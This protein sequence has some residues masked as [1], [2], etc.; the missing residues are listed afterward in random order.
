MRENR[1]LLE[2][3][4]LVTLASRSASTFSH[5]PF[6]ENSKPD[7]QI[8][9]WLKPAAAYRD[10]IIDETS[11]GITANENGAYAIVLTGNCEVDL[12]RDQAIRYTAAVD[13]P[14]VFRLTKTMQHEDPDQ[15]VVRVL[16]S[17]K[18]RSKIA[19]KAGLRYDGLWV[20]FSPKMA[21]S[22]S[23]LIRK[24][25]S[26]RILSFSVHLSPPNT[27]HTAFTLSRVPTQ[28]SLLSAL[29]NPTSDQLDDW[30]DYQRLK[31][32]D[33]GDDF[34]MLREILASEATGDV[35]SRDDGRHGSEDSGY[36]SRKGSKA[37]SVGDGR[38]DS[39][40][41]KELEDLIGLDTTNEKNDEEAE[42]AD[43]EGAGLEEDI[44]DYE[45]DAVSKSGRF[46][47]RT[48]EPRTTDPRNNPALNLN[49]APSTK[50]KLIPYSTTQTHPPTHS[51][52]V[53]PQ[54]KN[55]S[56]LA[57]RFISPRR[58][59]APRVSADEAVGG[60]SAVE[61]GYLGRM[62]RGEH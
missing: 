30:K 60:G 52:T 20:S 42:E 11:H 16:R 9:W 28:P 55:Q 6:P 57:P 49:D 53:T 37:A 50:P 1:I 19:P 8:S 4:P 13:D 23:L 48:T 21:T 22:K 62:R 40:L 32:I 51:P 46:A 18:L 17:W 61:G 31:L 2:H 10:G 41:R 26:Y 45:F 3:T 34:A 7:F 15:K 54:Q 35:E 38:R 43:D 47:A 5:G 27:W 44:E 24:R 59:A 56:H 58:P 12:G 33:G 14:G 25:H 29:Q 39:F 36:F